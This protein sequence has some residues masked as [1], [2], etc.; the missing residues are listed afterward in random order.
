[1]TR[2]TNPQYE[3]RVTQ[4]MSLRVVGSNVKVAQLRTFLAEIPNKANM[5]VH[6]TKA[7]RPGELGEV[8]FT[9]SWDEGSNN[10]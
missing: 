10:G 7:D 6:S 4:S 8:I 9:A 1:M 2:E 5:S 3:P